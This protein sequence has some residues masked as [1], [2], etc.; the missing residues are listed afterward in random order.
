MIKCHCRLSTA[1]QGK[2]GHQVV[3]LKHFLAT[4]SISV[5]SQ[6][7]HSCQGNFPGTPLYRAVLDMLIEN[8]PILL[9]SRRLW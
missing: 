6:S 5:P 8:R 7:A 4:L 9:E 2:G 1:S 3:L